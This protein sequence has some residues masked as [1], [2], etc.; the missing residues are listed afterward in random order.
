VSFNVA[1]SESAANK[2]SPNK[3]SKGFLKKFRIGNSNEVQFFEIEMRNH[4]TLDRSI[5]EAVRK[6]CAERFETKYT[7]GPFDRIFM[8]S[9]GEK[10]QKAEI[11]G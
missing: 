10:K 2:I 11:Y 6:Y 4:E 8:D 9:L 1:K 5:Y 7:P 3:F